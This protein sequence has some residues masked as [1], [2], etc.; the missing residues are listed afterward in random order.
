M[1]SFCFV[2]CDATRSFTCDDVKPTQ[3]ENL[4]KNYHQQTAF[5]ILTCLL[6]E[7]NVVF[8]V[9]QTAAQNITGRK[10]TATHVLLLRTAAEAFCEKLTSVPANVKWC[11]RDC[12]SHP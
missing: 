9:G 4:N 8:S 1:S 3:I 6:M 10:M 7:N 11:S 5:I 2:S 12:L